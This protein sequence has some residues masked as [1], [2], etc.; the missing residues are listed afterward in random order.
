VSVDRLRSVPLFAGLPDDDLAR[1]D[2]SVE[3]MSLSAGEQLFSEGDTGSHGYVIVDGELEVIKTAGRRETLLAL[4]GPGEVLGEMALLQEAPRMASVRAGSDSVLLA[5]P[6]AA[7]DDL[8]E[9]SPSLARA[10]LT[11][12]LER[13]EETNQR[14]RHTDRMAQLGTLTAGVA[15]E[16][17]NPAAAIRRAAEMLPGAIAE[18]EQA[19]AAATG[20]AVSARDLAPETT[21]ELNPLERADREEEIERWLEG[22]DIP[23]GWRLAPGLVDAGFD[24]AALDKLCASITAEPADL[25]ALAGAATAMRELVATVAQG[26]ARLSGIVGAL[27]SYSHLDRAPV[28]QID[29]ATG[30]DDTLLLLAHKLDGIEV[31]RELADDLPPIT[32]SGSELNQVWT[33]L[34]DNA[35]DALADREDA[36]IAIRAARDGDEVVVEVQDNGPGIPP[37]ALDRVF[38]PFFTTKPPGQGTGLGLQISQGIV[39][40]EHRGSLEVESR[41]GRTVFTVRL[42]IRRPGEGEESP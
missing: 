29:L 38:D 36:V 28:D 11:T 13:W 26:A 21:E 34:I 2:R 18:Y 39:V 9:T 25:V 14:L 19:L 15:H 16:L 8:L 35:A 22:R 31:V 37:D 20:S 42:P 23:D 7:L 30:I 10:M 33:N 5:I 6:K 17:N 1:L 27:K 24:V 41:P 3:E 12:L 4:R 32:G 40:M